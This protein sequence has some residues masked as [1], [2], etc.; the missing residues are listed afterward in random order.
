MTKK[1]LQARYQELYGEAPEEKVTVKQLTTLIEEKEQE[2]TGP[3]EQPETPAAVSLEETGETEAQ[4]AE[5]I[6]EPVDQ[7]ESLP[8][9]LEDAGL[10]SAPA[11]K[12]FVE[13]P[14]LLKKV[15]GKKETSSKTYY[16]G[17][18]R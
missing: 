1:E 17:E 5:S 10:E 18:L 8:E 13:N 3:E 15:E 14:R 7:P 9:A 12:V 6:E 4:D 16:Y 11:E 2:S